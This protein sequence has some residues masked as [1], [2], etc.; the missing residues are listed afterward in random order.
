[1]KR[2]DLWS[3]LRFLVIVIAGCNTDGDVSKS[4]DASKDAPVA[5]PVYVV[6][7]Y[8]PDRDPIEDLAT[9]VSQS[10]RDGKRIILEV[11][12]NW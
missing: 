12:G 2:Y 10:G 5:K 7:E 4:S 8:D 9:T 1:M 6:A 11:G 3:S